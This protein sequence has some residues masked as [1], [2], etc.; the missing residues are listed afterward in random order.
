MLQFDGNFHVTRHDGQFLQLGICLK[1]VFEEQPKD[2]TS[3]LR[4][5][6][7]HR[8]YAEQNLPRPGQKLEDVKKVGVE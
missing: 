6:L 4:H 3:L 8:M 7:A 1:I 2:L 5:G